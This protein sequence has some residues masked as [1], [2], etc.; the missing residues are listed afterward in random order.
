[1]GFIVN[2]IWLQSSNHMNMLNHTRCLNCPDPHNIPVALILPII[3]FIIIFTLYSSLF[4]QNDI[5]LICICSGIICTDTLI[6]DVLMQIPSIPRGIILLIIR[7]Y[8]D[9]ADVLLMETCPK[10]ECIKVYTNKS[11]SLIT[12]VDSNK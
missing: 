9:T 3:E 1:M 10:I 12:L 11:Y 5:L 6:G 7:Q 4:A 2:L 8:V